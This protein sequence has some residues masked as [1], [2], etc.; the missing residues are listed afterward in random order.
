MKADR[1]QR[2]AP[3]PD[4]SAGW[5][6]LGPKSREHLAAVG[7]HTAADLRAHD[8]FDV[9]ARVKARWPGASRNLV[10]ALLGAQEGRDWRDIARERRTEVLLRL[11]DM[12]LAPR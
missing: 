7:I 5:H 8:A 2:P 3:P 1:P 10:Y 12:G 6:H 4:G 11:D 9:Y